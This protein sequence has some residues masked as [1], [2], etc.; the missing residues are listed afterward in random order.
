YPASRSTAG[1]VPVVTTSARIPRAARA[2]TP[3]ALP[4]LR[5]GRSDRE[6]SDKSLASTD[7]YT[8]GSAWP[9]R[10]SL[11]FRPRRLL[12]QTLS[13]CGFWVAIGL[14]RRESNG[15]QL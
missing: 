5:T 6:A 13:S 11:P 8:P 2:D 12:A 14:R 9:A 15:F 1:L 10:P 4:A 3:S 7:T